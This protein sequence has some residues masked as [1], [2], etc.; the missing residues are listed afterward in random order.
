MPFTRISSGTRLTL[1][2]LKRNFSSAAS[3]VLYRL[4]YINMLG[5]TRIKMTPSSWTSRGRF[6]ITW[7]IR[8]LTLM[9]AWSGSVPRSKTT[10]IVASPA[11]V[12]SET[13]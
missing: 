13:M 6:G 7:S 12:A 3:S 2:K 9:I 4:T 1:A 10:W 11:L 8:V 5:M